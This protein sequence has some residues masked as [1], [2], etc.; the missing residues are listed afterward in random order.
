MRTSRAP[1]TC[2][3]RIFAASRSAGTRMQ[4]FSPQPR[5]LRRHA[6]REV[7]GR[8]AAHYIKPNACAFASATLTTRSLKLSVGKQT[9]SFFT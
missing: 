7:A 6:V 8:G 9:E 4:A 1:Y 2:V 5:R 3:F